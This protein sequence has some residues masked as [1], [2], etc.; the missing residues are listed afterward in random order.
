MSLHCDRPRYLFIL[1]EHL[2]RGAHGEL[3]INGR[4]N[5]RV[6]Q[7]KSRRYRRIDHAT[8]YIAERTMRTEN[9]GYAADDHRDDEQ[10]DHEQ[11]HEKGD[12][13]PVTAGQLPTAR[14]RGERIFQ[15]LVGQKRSVERTVGKESVSQWKDR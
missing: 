5:R 11:D 8:D 7:A 15:I 10:R 12:P 4:Q 1:L 3:A 13:P 14:Q 6:E 9:A 2:A